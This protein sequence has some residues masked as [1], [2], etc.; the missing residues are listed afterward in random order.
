MAVT[1]A[2]KAKTLFPVGLNHLFNMHISVADSVLALLQCGI[3]Y[4]GNVSS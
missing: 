2:T 4:V 1:R 3:Y